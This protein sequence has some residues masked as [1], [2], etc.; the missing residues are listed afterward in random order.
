LVK[1]VEADGWQ[2]LRQ[3]GSH[4]QYVHSSK[5]GVVTI[6]GKPSDDVPKGTLDAILK[7]A[8]VKKGGKS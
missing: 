3:K 8:N 1:L 5:P 4:A 7:Q 2:F 6:A